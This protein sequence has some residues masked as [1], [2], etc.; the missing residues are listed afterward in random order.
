MSFTISGLYIYPVK[1]CAGLELTEAQV[2]ETGFE[3]DREWMVVKQNGWFVT[4]RQFPR[5]TLIQPN[6]ATSG[7]VL[8]APDM[9]NITVPVREG[10]S[11]PTLD[12]RVWDDTM[13]GADQGDEAADW[14]STFLGS[15]CRLVRMA[16]RRPVGKKYQTERQ[17][18]TSFADGFP[19]L[20]IGQS[21]LDDLNARMETPV[22][23]SRFRP[24]IVVAGAA[25]FAEDD[26]KQVRIDGVNFRVVKQTSRCEMITIDQVTATKDIEPME[27]LGTFRYR[28]RGIMFGQYLVQESDDV[29]RT[30]GRLEVI[31]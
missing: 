15:P 8:S 28:T 26:W 3:H 4:Q 14:L 5:M 11:V 9:P 10:A 18:I 27:T 7:L 17:E 29:V 13:T 20:L 25:P 1:S 19:F 30:G 21:S 24:N 22:P 23:M 31:N 16:S 6:V 12:V 2:A